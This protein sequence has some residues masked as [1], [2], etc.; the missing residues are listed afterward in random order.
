MDK[1][2]HFTFYFVASVLGCMAIRENRGGK[3]PLRKTGLII[4][5]FCTL[6][7]IVIEVVQENFTEVRKGDIGDVLANT[8][9]ASAGL[10]A[11]NFLFSHKSGLKWKI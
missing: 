6:Y 3:W 10:L 2:V 5:V 8:I 1:A 11:V 4:L 9:G 7:G